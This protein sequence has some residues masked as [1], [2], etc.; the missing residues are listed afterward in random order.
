MDLNILQWN[1][2]GLKNN[3]H[4]LQ[5][6]IQDFNPDIISIQ[7]THIPYNSNSF[8]C[9]RQYNFFP[10]NLIDNTT[11]KQGIGL[12]I[13]KSIPHK[14]VHTDFVISS[15]AV[16]IN[17]GFKLTIICTY[18]PPHQNF[19]ERQLKNIIQ[20]INTPLILTGDFNSWSILWGST[21]SNISGNIIENFILNEDLIV[22]NDGSPTHFTTHNSFTNVDI[23]MCSSQLAPICSW[24]TLNYLHGSDHYPIF[25]NVCKKVPTT[26]SKC[27]PKFKTDYADWSLFQKLCHEHISNLKKKTHVL[28]LINS[29]PLLP[30]A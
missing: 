3:Y 18:I 6:L 23:T 19:S 21:N 13:K 15:I 1:I 11:S 4:E 20:Q 16:E 17:I 8:V 5:L 28:I 12:L 2:N 29:L 25:I 26:K 9:P 27:M 14:L 22:L 30:N 10:H 7:E 24:K